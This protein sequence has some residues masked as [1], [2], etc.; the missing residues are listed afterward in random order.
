[1]IF[2]AVL[3]HKSGDQLLNSF[4]KLNHGGVEL[5]VLGPVQLGH[6]HAG[7]NHSFG[8]LNPLGCWCLHN[9]FLIFKVDVSG[10]GAGL[11]IQ[12]RRYNRLRVLMGRHV[13]CNKG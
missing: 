3:D 5:L 7:C 12:Y 8:G 1:M 11:Q 2:V 6:Y 9:I 4:S 13:D 10:R